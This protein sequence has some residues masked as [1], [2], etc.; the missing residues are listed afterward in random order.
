MS[1]PQRCCHCRPIMLH[2]TEALLSRHDCIKEQTIGSLSGSRI[3][4]VVNI[5]VSIIISIVIY[6]FIL[7]NLAVCFVNADSKHG[8]YNLCYKYDINCCFTLYNQQYCSILLYCNIIGLY[9]DS[10][11]ICCMCH[12]LMILFI[13]TKSLRVRLLINSHI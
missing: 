9:Y 1:Q 13:M 3:F 11:T 12:K 10:A 6:V 5:F 2:E 4:A 7:R 8:S